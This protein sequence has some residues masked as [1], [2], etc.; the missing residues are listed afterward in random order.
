LDK[1]PYLQSRRQW[2]WMGWYLKTGREAQYTSMC[3]RM[4]MGLLYELDRI[5]IELLVCNLTCNGY[6]WGA[7]WR[8]AEKLVCNAYKRGSIWRLAKKL[9]CNL[10][11]NGY[12]RCFNIMPCLE[13][14]TD[15]SL[16][17]SV[18]LLVNLGLYRRAHFLSERAR[19]NYNIWEIGFQIWGFLFKVYLTSLGARFLSN[20]RHY[21]HRK[22][23]ILLH[24]LIE[25]TQVFVLSIASLLESLL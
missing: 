14:R 10:V 8:Q 7:T 12:E 20:L 23:S 25:K 1:S 21:F 13:P 19:K 16:L 17:E 11:Y 5:W 3:S 18:F 9:A 15:T 2:I 4:P 22:K 6:R 24:V